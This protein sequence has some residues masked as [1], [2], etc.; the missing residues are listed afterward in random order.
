[1]SQAYK[2]RPSEL[3]GVTDSLVA[4]Y[5]DRAAYTL[6]SEI[7]NEMELA[8]K[9]LPSNAKEAAHTRARQR[10]LDSYL[11]IEDSAQPNRFRSPAS[12]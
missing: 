12:K 6:A 3:L 10:I 8:T 5:T 11:G 2:C 7:E 4:F 1:M 9:R